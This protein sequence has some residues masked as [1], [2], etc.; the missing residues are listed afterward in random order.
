VI[1]FGE[2]GFF[3]DDVAARGPPQADYRIRGTDKEDNSTVKKNSVESISSNE[4]T[5]LGGTR[6]ESSNDRDTD[7]EEDDN[8]G[9]GTSTDSSWDWALRPLALPISGRVPGNGLGSG[10]GASKRSERPNEQLPARIQQDGRAHRRH[11]GRQR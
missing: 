11:R 1:L 9:D 3:L 2:K 5:T 8:E 10:I 4:A 7:D 6:A